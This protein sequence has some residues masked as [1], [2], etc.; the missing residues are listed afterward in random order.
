MTTVE[1]PQVTCH[2]VLSV[3]SPG[4][5]VRNTKSQS[6]CLSASTKEE[7]KFPF[8]H[9]LSHWGGSSSPTR[10]RGQGGVSQIFSKCFGPR[11]PGAWESSEEEGALCILERQPFCRLML[12]LQGGPGLPEQVREVHAVSRASDVGTQPGNPHLL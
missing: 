4:L 3:S 10:R 7:W 6:V 2:P 5:G 1:R 8:S 9:C 11:P 12:C